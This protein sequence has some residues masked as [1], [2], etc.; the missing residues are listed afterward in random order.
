MFD[1]RAVNLTSLN[2]VK[3]EFLATIQL[4]TNQLEQ[5]ISSRERQDLVQSCLESF[6][7]I[8]G[9]LRMVQLR[10]ADMLAG[11]IVDAL[12]SV[13]VGAD[14]S[15]DA[16]LAAVSTASFVVTR[17]FEYVQQFEKSMPVLLLPFIN[18]LRATRKLAPIPDS[19]FL[20]MNPVGA[21][22]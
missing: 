10:G 12:K 1:Q 8:D 11:E 13:P 4:A 17:Y 20:V 15:Y 2:I 5:F 6:Q 18:D 7:Q 16:M 14:A 9:V 21:P 3:G 22:E 19:H